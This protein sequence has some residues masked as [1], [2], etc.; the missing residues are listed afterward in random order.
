[1]SSMRSRLKRRRDGI[2]EPSRFWLIG[3]YFVTG[4]Y[5]DYGRGH[6]AVTHKHRHYIEAYVVV[7]GNQMYVSVYPVEERHSVCIHR[8]VVKSQQE[9]GRYPLMVRALKHIERFY[10]QY[11][12]IPNETRNYFSGELIET[13]T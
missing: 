12:E 10:E 3:D 8:C 6:Y 2:F 4:D 5:V 11:L 1:M 9:W 13:P 7:R